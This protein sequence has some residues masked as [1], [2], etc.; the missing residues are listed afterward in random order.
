MRRLSVLTGD[1]RLT[2]GAHLASDLRSHCALLIIFGHLSKTANL[3]SS[4]AG[5]T[6]L[7]LSHPLHQN[8]IAVPRITQFVFVVFSS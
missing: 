6:R 1:G 3:N 4:F 2:C 5:E 7:S 8:F